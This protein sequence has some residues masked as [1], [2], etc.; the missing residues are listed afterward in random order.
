M[1]T[2]QSECRP[3][4]GSRA[5]VDRLAECE[6]LQI[7]EYRIAPSRL[8]S[9]AESH[10]LSFGPASPLFPS[11]PKDVTCLSVSPSHAH[12][13]LINPLTREYRR[14]FVQLARAVSTYIRQL[15]PGDQ[16]IPSPCL[17]AIRYRPRRHPRQL[18]RYSMGSFPS[19]PTGLPQD[20]IDQLR[21]NR[22]IYW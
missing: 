21:S 20:P 7:G 22:P 19:R 3:G 4:R 8:W 5:L 11:S 2:D 15:L 10:R 9:H 6:D 13:P 14:R 1:V 18:H 17:L 16:R 12:S